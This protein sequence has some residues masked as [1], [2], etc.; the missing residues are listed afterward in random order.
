[1]KNILMVCLG[2]ICRS[3]IAHGVLID[4]AQ[5][6]NIQLNVDSAGTGNWHIG[7]QP[8][9]RS[10]N[11]AKKHD[12]DISNQRARQISKIDLDKYDIVFVMDQQNYKDVV[13]LCIYPEQRK[14][15]KLI[16]NEVKNDSNESVPDPY[17]DEIHGFENVFN[18]LDVACQNIINK[19]M[20][21]EY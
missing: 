14:K 5:K 15:V 3:P 6:N 2:N 8:D 12:I 11:T 21:D 9:I 19:L 10:I 17:Y 13:N 7:S 4:K 1:M 18:L 16:L 20:K